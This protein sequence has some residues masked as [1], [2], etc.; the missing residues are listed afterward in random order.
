[1]ASPS[2][3][4]GLLADPRFTA[5]LRDNLKAPQAFWSTPGSPLSDA[6]R[7]FLAEGAVASTDNRYFTITGCVTDYVTDG[8][9]GHCSQQR[10]LL[11]LDLGHP[12]S[13]LIFAALRW[14]EAGKIPGQPN[15]PF[16]LW[17]FPSKLLDAQRLPTAFKRSLAAWAE[18]RDCTPYQISSAIVVDPSGVPHANG[19]LNVGVQPSV[20]TKSSGQQK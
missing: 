14:N 20:C 15:A 3:K 17:I 2:N 8:R 5:L 18:S 6:A 9:F 4:S 11:W 19:S 13:L 10:G 1:Y 7:A 16:T 12:D